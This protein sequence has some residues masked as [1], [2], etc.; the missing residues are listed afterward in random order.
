[1]NLLL[2]T[3]VLIDYV[4][5]RAPF[6]EDA[7]RVIAAGYFGDAR[8]WMA[9]QS[10]TDIFYVLSKYAASVDIQR[11]LEKLYEVVMPVSLTSTDLSRATRLLWPDYEDCLISLAAE[12]CRADYIVTRDT[13]GF[14]R[15]CVPA[16]YPSDLLKA[17]EGRGIFYEAVDLQ[18]DH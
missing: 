11:S 15:S 3:N 18:D 7:E 17:M 4:G 14:D 8:L 16:V 1:M 10:A 12:N 5:R 13:R 9:A 6:F 2:D